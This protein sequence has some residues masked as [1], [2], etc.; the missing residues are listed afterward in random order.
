MTVEQIKISIYNGEGI[1]LANTVWEAENNG[2]GVLKNEYRSGLGPIE[3]FFEKRDYT[4]LADGV[5]RYI[6]VAF[7]GDEM[8]LRR[9][10]KVTVKNGKI[11]RGRVASGIGN[12][13]CW[14]N[15]IAYTSWKPVNS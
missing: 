7:Q 2:Y 10:A 14:G 12:S 8:W 11:A 3:S 1:W 4:K 9:S 6:V 5:Y 13:T 15:K